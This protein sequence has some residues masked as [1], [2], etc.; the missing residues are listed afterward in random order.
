MR[1]ENIAVVIYG[2][3]GSGKGTQASLAAHA[4]GLVNFDTGHHL[5]SL[6]YDPK[7]QKDPLIKRERKLFEEGKLN[8]PSFVLAE[9]SKAVRA[10]AKKGL[11]VVFSGSPRTMYEAERLIPLLV[12]LYK[13]KGVF[14]FFLD[15]T[16]KDAI[17]RNSKRRLCAI[18]KAPLLAKY[19][20]STKPKFCPVCAGPLYKRTL[21]DKTIIPKR[22]KEYN[23]RTAPIL[24]YLKKLGY[25]INKVDGRPEPFKVFQL[26][27]KPVNNGLR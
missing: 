15:V 7:R 14:F 24:K 2:L 1:T 18:C 17:E 12:S 19:Y 13:K 5:E 25:R 11:G 10:I 4:Y 22:V 27:K 21:D 23:E 3:P 20:P 9:V 26:L 6:W 8:T 16:Q